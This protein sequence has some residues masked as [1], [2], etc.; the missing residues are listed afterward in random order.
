M[1]ASLPLFNGTITL[2][3]ALETEDNI[4]QQ[5]SYLE[6]Q[7]DFFVYFY[8]RRHDIEAIV[9]CHF[10]VFDKTCKARETKEWIYGSFNVCIPIYVN[11]LVR[12][13]NKKVLIKIFLPYKISKPQYFGNAKEKLHCK[14]AIY[15]WIQSNCPMGVWVFWRPK[16]VLSK[17]E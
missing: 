6:K 14:V 11:N 10:G 2:I 15:I 8:Q 4:L 16:R 9:L 7:L 12:Y 1:L 3:K 5:L 17:I 13:H